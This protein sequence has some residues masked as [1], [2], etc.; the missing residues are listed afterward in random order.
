MLF[1]VVGTAIGGLLGGALGGMA[2]GFLGD[3][4]T[5]GVD[6]A[7]FTKPINDGFK[8]MGN[9]GEM[10][11]KSMGKKFGTNHSKG[12]FIKTNGTVTPI[13]NADKVE[14]IMASKPGGG[15]DR[16]KRE[17]FNKS[18]NSQ[19]QQGVSNSTKH[20]FE[21]IKGSITVEIPGLNK[22]FTLEDK[23]A[24]FV[25]IKEQIKRDYSGYVS[26]ARNKNK[27]GGKPKP[28]YTA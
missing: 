27:N 3:L 9:P 28:S 1:P 8:N 12:N 24:M 22:S 10:L 26:D 23:D 19:Q 16:Y 6:D 4:D 13:H 21:P 20:S 17:M 2:G 11:S 25:S 18:T 14:T 7:I 5:Y 15:I